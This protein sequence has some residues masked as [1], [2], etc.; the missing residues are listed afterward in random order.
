MGREER[1][2]LIGVDTPETVHT[3]IGVEPFGLEASA[4]TKQAPKYAW[5]W[6]CRSGTPMAGCSP[7]STFRMAGC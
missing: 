2:R 5:S 1:V 7:T 3:Q 6:T 4:F